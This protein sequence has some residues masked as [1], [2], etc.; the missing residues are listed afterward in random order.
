MPQ[1]SAVA[2][3]LHV[4]DFT[5]SHLGLTDGLNSQRIFSLKQTED[6]A[7]WLTTQSFV[8]RYNG[9]SIENFNLEGNT[10]EYNCFVQSA[11]NSVLQVFDAGG[12]IYE[13]N[14]EQNHF[15]VVADVAVFSSMTTSST[16]CIRTATFTGWQ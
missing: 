8:A 7:V 12:R 5:F 3:A 15:D 13:Y 6:G 9:V 1:L 4:N 10:G 2:A 14:P 11:D 16:M